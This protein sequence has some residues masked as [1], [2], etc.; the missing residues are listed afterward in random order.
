M[1]QT[2][3][4][5]LSRGIAVIPIAYRSKWPDA[6]LLPIK[7]D[8]YGQPVIKKNGRIQHDWETYQTRLPTEQ[9]V[10]DWFS[11]GDHNLA[12][13]TGWRNLIVVD[14]DDLQ[15]YNEW[16][17]K[18]TLPPTYSV[19]TTRGIHLYFYL[20]KPTNSFKLTKIDV[21]ARGK[22][23]VTAPSVHS[24][25]MTY[26]ALDKSTP[27]L[28]VADISDVLDIPKEIKTII[29]PKPGTNGNGR[30]LVSRVKRNYPILSFFPGAEKSGDRWYKTLCPF[31]DD[32]NAS[33]WIDA[34]RGLCGCFA[35]CTVKPFDAIDL[36][37][38]LN[39]MSIE[40]AI[41]DMQDRARL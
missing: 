2:A 4:N 15:V 32:H 26:I 1:L 27:I 20:H 12:I 8:Q 18:S 29:K 33:F 35:G 14:F 13:V 31:H 22:Y 9:Q 19:L 41:A 3:L 25:G 21:Q 5:W 7:Y 36:Y 38:V 39:N 37:A 23:A 24:S 17:E 34:S 6:R 16:Q 11:A 30:D 28:S 40:E 10:K